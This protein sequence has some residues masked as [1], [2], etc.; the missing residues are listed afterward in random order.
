[1]SRVPLRRSLGDCHGATIV[2]MAIVSSTVLFILI[3]GIIGT[4]MFIQAQISL[5]YAVE[6]AARCAAVMGEANNSPCPTST[7]ATIESY[8]ANQF[9]N[10][11]S[12]VTP[13]FTATTPVNGC[14][15]TAQTQGPAGQQVSA[16]YAFRSL[17]YPYVP[18]KL[19][20]SASACY[21]S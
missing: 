9:V 17:L 12:T 11:S 7:P 16:T 4:G 1:M 2:E 21:P 6:T 19:T 14:G 3:F 13:V 5:N 20:L 18:F 8:A 15:G 10:L